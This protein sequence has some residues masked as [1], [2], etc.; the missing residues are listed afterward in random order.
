MYNNSITKGAKSQVE[1]P[2]E[3]RTISEG[4]SSGIIK[5]VTYYKWINNKIV[6][7]LDWLG[8]EKKARAAEACGSW[9]EIAQK[10]GR[11]RIVRANF[12]RE[13]V[14]QICAWRR[15]MKFI[16]Q[17]L[18]TLKEVEKKHKF[19]FVTLTIK[20]VKGE[21]APEAITTLLDAWNKL[22]KRRA[23]ARAWRGFIRSVEITYNVE[24]KEFHPHIHALV[25]VKKTYGMKK[26]PEYIS[27]EQLL[28]DWKEAAGL[29]YRPDVYI[30]VVRSYEVD[31]NAA[32]PNEA[33]NRA[34]IE[35]MKYAFK[36]KYD[37]IG[38]ETV[39]VFLDALKNRRLISF[40]GVIAKKRAEIKELQ[41]ERF[42]A[43]CENNAELAT[44]LYKFSPSGWSIEEQNVPEDAGVYEIFETPHQ[45]DLDENY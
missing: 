26:D 32:R 40:G 22:Y 29:D 33:T 36:V 28:Q 25:A 16:A 10:E 45:Y 42:R 39:R 23:Y 13:R 44:V 5:K 37:T 27:F 17:M 20:N 11:E 38:P 24:D 4:V 31:K 3:W 6:A 1:M 19:I 43:E 9:V 21:H 34:A 18:P 30:S 14:C 2:A 7:A 35:T 8:E 12:C 15:S 41:E